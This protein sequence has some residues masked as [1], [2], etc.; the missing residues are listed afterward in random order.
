MKTALFSVIL[1]LFVSNLVKAQEDTSLSII[2]KVAKIIEVRKSFDSK[3]ETTKPALFSYKKIQDEPAIYSI[4][5][6]VMYKGMDFND[7][8]IFPAIQLLY[9]SGGKKR[10]EL[11]ELSLFGQID[12]YNNSE[13]K[14]LLEPSF[15]Y[16]ED[17]FTKERII[18]SKIVFN[19]SY[20][21]FFIPIRNVTN[22]KFKYNGKDNHWVFGFNPII[23]FGYEHDLED[24]S[25][26]NVR[27]FY[28]IAHGSISLKRYYIEITAYGEYDYQFEDD[29]KSYYKYGTIVSI[30]LDSK[31]RSSVNAKIENERRKGDHDNEISFGFGLR[32]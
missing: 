22:Y 18:R 15:T 1:F 19:P 4:D 21:D 5:A 26:N 31:E 6:A 10:R 20:R 17:F 24:N 25:S 27:S 32:L 2:D 13:G 8:G 3:S 7:F 30:Y 9:T 12:L 23:G 14:G 16:G 29:L 11:V 28:N